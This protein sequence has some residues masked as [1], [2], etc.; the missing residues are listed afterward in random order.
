MIDINSFK[1]KESI[2]KEETQIIP[3]LKNEDAL[4]ENKT[5]N[6]GAELGTVRKNENTMRLKKR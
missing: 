3:F 6:T 1:C 5:H 2:N 4:F